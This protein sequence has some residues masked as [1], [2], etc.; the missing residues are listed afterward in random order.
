MNLHFGRIHIQFIAAEGSKHIDSSA[1]ASTPAGQPVTRTVH[2]SGGSQT[3]Y[4]Y[5][6]LE[7]DGQRKGAL[8]LSE[9]AD[10]EQHFIETVVTDT[11]TA[12]LA[13]ALLSALLSFVMGQWLVGRPVHALARRRVGLDAAISPSPS[14]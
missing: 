3:W 1:L 10:R 9:T 14:R 12:A 8:E 13:L 5:V 4:T 7:V 2:A 11:T 6:P